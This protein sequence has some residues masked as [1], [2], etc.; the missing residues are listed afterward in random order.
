[1]KGQH[2]DLV[3]AKEELLNVIERIN[4]ETTKLFAETFQ[5]VQTNFREMFKGSSDRP[6]EG[7]PHPP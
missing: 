4:E 2:D 3:T 6:L 7:G 5:Q 1:M